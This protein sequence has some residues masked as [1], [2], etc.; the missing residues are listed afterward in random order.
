MSTRISSGS[1]VSLR[2]MCLTRNDMGKKRISSSNI[3]YSGQKSKFPPRKR[4]RIPHNDKNPKFLGTNLFLSQFSTLFLVFR[5]LAT[6]W[7]LAGKIWTPVFRFLATAWP[8][9]AK[10]WT[11]GMTLK[12]AIK[13]DWPQ[14]LLDFYHFGEILNLF[15]G[16]NLLSVSTVW[17]H[18]W[19][20]I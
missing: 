13:T 5:F 19:H 2:H 6:A 16:G 15:R 17:V 4:S 9:A 10:I 12:T 18:N 1:S 8:L 20:P 14:K 3:I 11:P 7:P